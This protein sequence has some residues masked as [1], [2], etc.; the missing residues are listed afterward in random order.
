[1]TVI[2][3]LH[4]ILRIAAGDGAAKWLHDEIDKLDAGHPAVEKAVA[5]AEDVVKFLAPPEA[6]S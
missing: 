6:T 3:I 2:E 5:D 4:E 1:M